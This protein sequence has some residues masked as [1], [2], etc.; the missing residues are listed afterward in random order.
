MHRGAEAS[1]G[2][3]APAVAAHPSILVGA[4]CSHC[5]SSQPASGG[6]GGAAVLTLQM[7]ASN[8]APSGDQFV[9]AG[10]ASARQGYATR[11][12]FASSR[13]REEKFPPW[14]TGTGVRPCF[15]TQAL[16]AQET[17]GPNWSFGGPR[18]F[19]LACCFQR[20]SEAAWAL[21]QA[22]YSATGSLECRHDLLPLASQ[23]LMPL[24]SNTPK[25]L[26]R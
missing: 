25:C 1:H 11:V 12:R 2:E 8:F 19:L 14:T 22:L 6:G 23:H 15:L 7:L 4:A 16:H 9:K 24:P 3:T 17:D 10:T 21:D 26:L 5:S 20:L 13:L 18:P